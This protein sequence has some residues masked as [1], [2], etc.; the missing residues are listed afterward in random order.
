MV[1]QCTACAY[2]I[3]THSIFVAPAYWR[4]CFNGENFPIYDIFCWQTHCASTSLATYHH[5]TWGN[6]GIRTL[7]PAVPI[8]ESIKPR[9]EGNG[10]E[11]EVNTL[12]TL[13]SKSRVH[14]HPIIVYCLSLTD[15]C[16]CN[17]VYIRCTVYN[18]NSPHYTPS[19]STW[20]LSLTHTVDNSVLSLT[21][22]EG[23]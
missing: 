10:M 4:K 8:Q 5:S 12:T 18:S 9:M 15:T 11:L 2:L 6:A 13:D 1:P 17:S 16:W 20:G 3:F 22:P 7:S 14:V 19:P 21:I 23:C